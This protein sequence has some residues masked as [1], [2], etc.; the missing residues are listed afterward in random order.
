[1]YSYYQ[2][3]TMNYCEDGLRA[4]KLMA[5]VYLREISMSL[6]LVWK[7]QHFSLEFLYM[8]WVI[9][10]NSKISRI[11]LFFLYSMIVGF[12]FLILL[13]MVVCFFC[14]YKLLFSNF[15]C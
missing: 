9:Q 10:E 6:L 5:E 2:Y 13:H 15:Y 12:K 8:Q 3:I 1:M 4:V 7:C 11:L 14:F